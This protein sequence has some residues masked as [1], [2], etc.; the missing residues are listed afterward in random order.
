M[1]SEDTGPADY[2]L[3]QSFFVDPDARY[4]RNLNRISRVLLQS[5]CVSS[6]FDLADPVETRSLVI[7]DPVFPSEHDIQTTAVRE[8]I[9]AVAGAYD[10]EDALKL[11]LES[12]FSHVRFL[13]AAPKLDLP[14]LRSDPR[15][16]LKALARTVGEARLHDFFCKPTT[17][18]LEP[19]DDGKDEGIGMPAS[20]VHF[21]HQLTKG[22]EPDDLDVSEEDLLY[23]AESLYNVWVDEDLNHLLHDEIDC[24]I[25]SI[26]SR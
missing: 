13:Q 24:T 25:T 1:A 11:A 14:S 5:T 4:P 10:Q 12:S 23:V 18:P 22:V 16:D 21:H 17:L 9:E 6:T 3:L 15:Q 8:I 2:A 19:V 20:A 26:L 7:P